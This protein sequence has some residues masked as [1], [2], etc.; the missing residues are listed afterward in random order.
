MAD[1]AIT[2]QVETDN[3]FRIQGS[4]P[5]FDPNLQM[6]S[7]LQNLP[8]SASDTVADLG[9][10]LSDLNSH[11]G[12]G[13]VPLESLLTSKTLFNTKSVNRSQTEEYEHFGSK[14]IKGQWKWRIHR[15]MR[16]ANVIPQK[17]AYVCLHSGITSDTVNLI[18]DH[19]GKI[20]TKGCVRC[21][22]LWSCSNCRQIA[23]REKRQQLRYVTQKSQ[24]DLVMLTLTMPHKKT[25]ELPQ[26][27]S[28]LKKAWNSFRND[29]QFKKIQKEHAFDWGVCSVEVTHGQNGFHPHYHIL[30]GFKDWQSE[31]LPRVSDAIQKIWVRVCDAFRNT[32]SLA[33]SNSFA[34][35]VTEIKDEF[36]EYVAKW[37]VYNEI[38]DS[39]QLKTGKNGNKSIAQLELEA[40]EQYEK[41]GWIDKN[42][43]QTLRK[44]YE[45]MTGT[46]FMNPFGSFNK[47]LKGFKSDEAEE[48]IDE[49]KVITPHENNDA[50]DRSETSDFEIKNKKDI[51][52]KASFW[53]RTLLR[54]GIAQE[55]KMMMVLEDTVDKFRSFL[56]GKVS[57]V[58]KSIPIDKIEM[59]IDFN[60]VIEGDF[61]ADF[62]PPEKCNEKF[63]DVDVRCL[64]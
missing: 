20:H 19:K 33:T 5:S 25:D 45:A 16:L 14:T 23:L 58:M 63:A 51:K 12:N 56:I 37:S 39:S 53:N 8:E 6:K 21:N 10:L 9:I 36:V 3:L 7:S 32:E 54:F 50:D 4:A 17:R 44:Y 47:T 42:L 49:G 57:K 26:L 11:D 52:I 41:K 27:M 62:S 35:K 38:A 30:L 59:M 29:R 43:H 28:T 64:A 18:Q 15:A 34:T 2:C 24:T 48:Q 13:T 22:M 61:E 46:K 55:L 40:T 60:V 1:Q 31:A